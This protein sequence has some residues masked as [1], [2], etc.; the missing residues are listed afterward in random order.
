M[1][2]LL[3]EDAVIATSATVPAD[4]NERPPGGATEPKAP[5]AVSGGSTAKPVATLETAGSP[6]EPLKP[7]VDDLGPDG[8]ARGASQFL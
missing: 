1:A 3:L 5:Q 7:T 2:V 6:G 8:R 4:T